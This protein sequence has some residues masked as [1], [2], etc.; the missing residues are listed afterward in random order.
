MGAAVQ[1]SYERTER[2]IAQRLEEQRAAIDDP[3]ALASSFLEFVRGD[4]LSHAEG[5]I[6]ASALRSFETMEEGQ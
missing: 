5:G 1:L 3:Q 4:P 2:P 6:V